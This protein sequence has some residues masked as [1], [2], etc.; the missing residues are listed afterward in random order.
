VYVCVCVCVCY[1]KWF[2]R[3][4]SVYANVSLC[5]IHVQLKIDMLVISPFDVLF[6]CRVAKKKCP[7]QEKAMQP[8]IK[9]E[10]VRRKIPTCLSPKNR[11]ACHSIGT[12]LIESI[13]TLGARSTMKRSIKTLQ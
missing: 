12:S 5:I 11:E 7:L 10:T 9:K 2:A 6:A 13:A 8:P 3:I 1:S 4:Y